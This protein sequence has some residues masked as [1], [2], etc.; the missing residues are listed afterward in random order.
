MQTEFAI[1]NTLQL[2][3]RRVLD[4]A[5]AV[6]TGAAAVLQGGRVLVSNAGQL[7]DAAA[8]Q[9]THALQI[10]L[11]MGQ[12]IGR[13]VELQELLQSRVGAVKIAAVAIGHGVVVGLC[14]LRH[15]AALGW[16]L[17]GHAGL[18]NGG[19][20]SASSWME[21]TAGPRCFAPFQQPVLFASNII[22]L[23]IDTYSI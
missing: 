4:D 23:F 13:Q 12:Q 8:G 19:A 11:Q 20:C 2:F 22:K 21:G 3:I 6:F 5:L 18:L 9:L 15:G 10:G 1:G 7:V 16:F 17:S 14:H